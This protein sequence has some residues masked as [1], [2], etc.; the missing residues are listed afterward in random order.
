MPHYLLS[1]DLSPD[2][3]DRRP[4]YRDA[5]LALAWKVADAGDLLLGGAVGDPVES[6]LL[7]FTDPDSARAFAEADPYVAEGLVRS[8]RVLPW[9]TVVGP[10]AATPVRPSGN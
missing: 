4:A 7:I 6:A 8:W 9:T 3:L 10:A 2:Y 1:Y 5:H